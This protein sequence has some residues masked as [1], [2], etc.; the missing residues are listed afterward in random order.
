MTVLVRGADSLLKGQG[1]V[2]TM[3]DGESH[4]LAGNLAA[5]SHAEYNPFFHDPRTGNVRTD[6]PHK[7]PMEA[8]GEN[9]ARDFIENKVT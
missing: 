8:L 1:V 4:I 3:D 9:M 7:F 5:P 2:A 6:I